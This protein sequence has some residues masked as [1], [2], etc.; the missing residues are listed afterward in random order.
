MLDDLDSTNLP[1]EVFHP[2]KSH[3]ICNVDETCIMGS[4]GALKIIGGG[5]RR[6]HN[7]NVEDYHDSITLARVGNAG[8]TSGPFIFLAKGKTMDVPT[9]QIWCPSTFYHH[10]DTKCIHD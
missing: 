4:V 6:K 2:I 1:A 10:H 3:F 5:K 7:K 8:R 9:L